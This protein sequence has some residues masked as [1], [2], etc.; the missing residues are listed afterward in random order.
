M[1]RDA[2]TPLDQGF[3]VYRSL[4]TPFQRAVFMMFLI[5][6]VHPFADGNGRISRIMMNSEL[7]AAKEQRIIIPTIYRANYLASLKAL[8]NRA[9][10]EPLIRTLDF[11]QRFMQ[12]IDW[13]NFAHAEGELR[14]ANAFM[15]SAEAE[16][17]GIRLRLLGP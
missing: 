17:R 10:P 14:D 11:A 2:G 8:S 5:A 7:V 15:D 16:E 9:S 6:E 4:T 13:S 3:K 12:S 1:L